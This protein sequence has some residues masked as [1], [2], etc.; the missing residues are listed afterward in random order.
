M[1]ASAAADMAEGDALVLHTALFFADAARDIARP[2][3]GLPH[4]LRAFAFPLGETRMS[5][6]GVPSSAELHSFTMTRSDGSRLYGHCCT[7]YAAAPAQPAAAAGSGGGAGGVDAGDDGGETAGTLLELTVLCVLSERTCHCALRRYLAAYVDGLPAGGGL[8]VRGNAEVH[9][10]RLVAALSPSLGSSA[11]GA[12]RIVEVGGRSFTF[13]GQPAPSDLPLADVHFPALLGALDEENLARLFG[14][15]LAEQQ[16]LVVSDSLLMLAQALEALLALFYPFEWCHTYIPILPI[17]IVVDMVHAP[18]PFLIGAHKSSVAAVPG[19]SGTAGSPASFIPPHVVV[20]DLDANTLH[21]PS[22]D[23]C[24]VAGSNVFHALPERL[25]TKLVRGIARNAHSGLNAKGAGEEQ[26]AGS[27]FS[28]SR[29][30]RDRCA[31]RGGAGAKHITKTGHGAMLTMRT[32]DVLYSS[33]E[34]D[35]GGEAG[36]AL[37]DVHLAARRTASPRGQPAQAKQVSHM[38]APG[39]SS[40][41]TLDEMR[42]RDIRY[43]FLGVFVSLLKSYGQHLAPDGVEN[44]GRHSRLAAGGGQRLRTFNAPH[45][46]AELPSDTEAFLD[47]LLSTQ[48]FSYFVQQRIALHASD[49]RLIDAF[50]AKCL[51]KMKRKATRLEQHSKIVARQGFSGMLLKAKHG[52]LGLQWK[53]Y[54]FTLQCT[55][56]GSVLQFSKLSD[57]ERQLKHELEQLHLNA[58]FMQ[59]SGGTQRD[60]TQEE[61]RLKEAIAAA[62]RKAFQGE[63]PLIP[64]ETTLTIPTFKKTE[65]ERFAFQL[66]N[67]GSSHQFR[68]QSSD[69]RKVWLKMLKAQIHSGEEIERLAQI[70]I[71][72]EALGTEAMASEQESHASITRTEQDFVNKL[73]PSCRAPSAAS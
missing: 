64:T 50:D 73:W 26:D 10:A 40:Q 57:K 66:T 25:H 20:V 55:E 4:N 3:E 27:L 69:E 15:M 41:L 17:L 19:M 39:G 9:V 37:A 8:A 72:K 71:R 47:W 11:G 62:Q 28:W 56:G 22:D 68:A 18:F 49:A 24:R 65:H 46:L 6:E 23:V 12:G 52:A 7:V 16:I 70:Y 43:L 34:S 29:G 44:A 5:A 51:A 67:K 14:A 32:K 35:T 54:V 60:I 45:F 21:A 36:P 61:L 48:I 31:E 53:K 63:I 38:A 59:F 1:A 58:K 42:V 2:E 33:S 13:P 30:G